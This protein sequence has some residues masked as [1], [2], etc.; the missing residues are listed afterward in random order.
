MAELPNGVVLVDDVEQIDPNEIPDR[1]SSQK[2][3]PYY[4]EDADKFNVSING[5]L[6]EYAIEYCISGKWVRVMLRNNDGKFYNMKSKPRLASHKVRG[7]VE[8]TRKT[9]APR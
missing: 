8:V 9:D 1:V 2:H 3:S 7:P 5:K 4:R 6:C